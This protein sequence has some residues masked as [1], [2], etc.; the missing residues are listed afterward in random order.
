MRFHSTHSMRQLFLSTVYWSNWNLKGWFLWI[1]ENQRTQSKTLRTRMR[2]NNN[3]NP[4]V[5][6]GWESDTRHNKG[7]QVLTPLYQSPPPLPK[8]PLSRF[9][10]S[11]GVLQDNLVLLTVFPDCFSYFSLSFCHKMYHCC[12]EKL[13]SD[14]CWNWKGL[15]YMWIA[16][17]PDQAAPDWLGLYHVRMELLVLLW[18]F[19]RGLSNQPINPLTPRSDQGRISP[20]NINTISS[21]EVMRIK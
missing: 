15:R 14:H 3:L 6:P 2:T 13:P 9:S 21:I 19:Q 12:K 5:T 1:E 18:P 16:P 20:Y 11:K 7:S 8:L 4:H 10:I 17:T